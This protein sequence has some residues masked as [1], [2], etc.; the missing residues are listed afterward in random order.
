M[1]GSRRYFRAIHSANPC[2]VEDL[3]TGTAM[4]LPLGLAVSAGCSLSSWASAARMVKVKRP[5]RVVE[6]LEDGKRRSEPRR[7]GATLGLHPL[8]E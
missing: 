8:F 2:S 3:N 7:R 6:I 5:A 1:R 4:L